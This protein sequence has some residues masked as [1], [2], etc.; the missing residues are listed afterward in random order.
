MVENILQV[1]EATRPFSMQEGVKT[2]DFAEVNEVDTSAISFIL[3]VKRRAL[4]ENATVQ[5]SHLP[6]NLISLM[7]L[8]GV[9]EFVDAQSLAWYQPPSMANCSE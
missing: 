4:A 6:S 2:L 1:L 7:Q 9:D 8:Y 5:L 3:E